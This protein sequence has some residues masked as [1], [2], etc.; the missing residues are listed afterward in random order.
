M[1]RGVV[2]R[3]HCHRLHWLPTDFVASRGHGEVDGTRAESPVVLIDISVPRNIETRCNSSKRVSLQLDDLEA[4][5][6]ENART[7]SQQLA[8]CNQ[9]INERAEAL[10][11]KLKLEKQRLHDVGVQSKPGWLSQG[12]LALSS[13]EIVSRKYTPNAGLSFG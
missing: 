6:C 13:G 2:G 3:G 11:A 8:P 9:I 10:M 7:R 12:V 4:I 1:F 5:V